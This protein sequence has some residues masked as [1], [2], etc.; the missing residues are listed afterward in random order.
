MVVEFLFLLSRFVLLCIVLVEIRGKMFLFHVRRFGCM[1]YY[2][3]T[4]GLVTW[5]NVSGLA[6]QL[7]WTL[8]HIQEK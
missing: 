8:L 6:S 3:L 1:C 2:F 4:L 5:V 7:T